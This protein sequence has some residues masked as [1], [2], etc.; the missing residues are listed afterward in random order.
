MSE[1]RSPLDARGGLLLLLFL[2]VLLAGCTVGKFDVNYPEVWASRAKEVMGQCPDLVGF[3]LNKGERRLSSGGSD[4]Y[5]NCGALISELKDGNKILSWTNVGDKE[6]I[7]DRIIEIQ[8]T[9][10]LVVDVTEWKETEGERKVMSQF[11][12]SAE[13]EDFQCKDGELWLKTRV[14]S[15]IFLVSNVLVTETRVFNKA[16]DGSLVMKRFTKAGGH[17]FVFPEAY[18]V[19]EW[20]RWPAVASPADNL[21]SS[22]ARLENNDQ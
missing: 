20:V 11:Q 21:R 3:Y 15:V 17:N 4:C 10:D 5:S 19:G 12:L 7:K 16:E 13:A 9:T 6:R 2:E 1:H 14:H 18:G 22:P 8:Q